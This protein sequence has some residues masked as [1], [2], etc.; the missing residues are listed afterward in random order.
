M[1]LIG[2][3]LACLLAL[4]MIQGCTGKEDTTS[5]E[6]KDTG[7]VKTQEEALIE[8]T[9]NDLATV[10]TQ[11]PKT[12]DPQSILRFYSQDYA[13]INNGQSESLKDI[14]KYLSEL[15]DRINLGE[16]IGISSKVAN[17][18]T[19]VTGASG[20]ATFEFEYKI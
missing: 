15:N 13:G 3:A 14:E 12:K 19:N 6:H 11:F 10:N 16:P 7:G 20:W 4:A 8:K 18:K 17:I 1:K 9:L 5:G 2:G